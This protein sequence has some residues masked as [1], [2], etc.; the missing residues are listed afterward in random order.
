VYIGPLPEAVRLFTVPFS[1]TDQ[2]N[3]AFR[4][5]AAASLLKARNAGLPVVIQ[6]DA[7]SSI[8]EQVDVRFTS[9]RPDGLK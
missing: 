2:V 8:I 5:V 6:H 4:R 3:L 1:G 9:V 7:G